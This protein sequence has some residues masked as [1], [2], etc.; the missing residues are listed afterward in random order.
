M[1]VK[2]PFLTKIW[3]SELC[4]R[5]C[6]KPCSFLTDPSEHQILVRNGV[7][8]FIWPQNQNVQV[9]AF[10]RVG[11]NKSTLRLG[12]IRTSSENGKHLYCITCNKVFL[13]VPSGPPKHY[14]EK[15]SQSLDGESVYNYTC[16]VYTPFTCVHVW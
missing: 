5:S 2:N 4:V 1:K 7:L 15:W 6:S 3:F 11:R 12:L 14:I 10:G 13:L 16:F 9:K 8:T